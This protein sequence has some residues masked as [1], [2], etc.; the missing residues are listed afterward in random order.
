MLIGS[1]FAGFFA[2]YLNAYY[3]G[4]FLKYSIWQQVRDILPSFGV[5]LTMAIIVYAISYIP[6]PVLPL[7]IIQITV[8]A[9][10]TI[11]LC[12]IFK[13]DEYEELKN[14]FLSFINKKRKNG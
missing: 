7:L 8:G 11:A 4:P 6:M 5:A 9:I 2:Y 13:L 10:V 14:I 12:T 3:S 1:V